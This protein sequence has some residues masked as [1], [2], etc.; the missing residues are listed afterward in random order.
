MRYSSSLFDKI[1]IYDI[2]GVSTSLSYN[3]PLRYLINNS[4]DTVFAYVC[5]I[6]FDHRFRLILADS[7]IIPPLCVTIT[8]LPTM[9]T[10]PTR[11]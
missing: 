11:R 1:D 3:F 2:Y 7:C 10:T 4:N 5:S 8:N 6:V 9:S